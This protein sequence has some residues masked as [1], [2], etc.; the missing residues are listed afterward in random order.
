MKDRD[1]RSGWKNIP[2][3]EEEEMLKDYNSGVLRSKILN[4]YKIP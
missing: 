3:S 1:I 2:L 4:K